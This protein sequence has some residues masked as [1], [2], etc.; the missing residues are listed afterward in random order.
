MEI[1]TH[2]RDVLSISTILGY[3]KTRI[4]TRARWIWSIFSRRR[5]LASWAVR[6]ALIVDETSTSSEYA[7]PAEGSEVRLNEA[8]T[9]PAKPCTCPR[10]INVTPP[11]V[12]GY[13]ANQAVRW[14]RTP[15]ANPGAVIRGSRGVKNNGV[16]VCARVISVPVDICGRPRRGSNIDGL[17]WPG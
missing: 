3:A 16:E 10:V 7:R 12:R 5:S 15:R 4:T 1:N 9:C 11:L 14:E 13:R 2:N 6:W 8:L 17:G